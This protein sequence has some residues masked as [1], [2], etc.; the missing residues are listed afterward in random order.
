MWHRWPEDKR[1]GLVPW[2][3]VLRRL[4]FWPLLLAGKVICFLAILGGFGL[5]DAKQ[6][7]RDGP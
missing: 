1:R 4:V 3:V 2:F 6:T 7:W 5:A